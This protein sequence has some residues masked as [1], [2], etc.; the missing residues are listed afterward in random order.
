MRIGILGFFLSFTSVLCAQNWADSLAQ[1]DKDTSA[2]HFLDEKIRALKYADPQ[3]TEELVVMYDSLASLTE[4]TFYLGTAMLHQADRIYSLQKYDEALERYIDI[5]N[6]LE[7][8]SELDLLAKANNNLGSCYQVRNDTKTS[9]AYFVKALDLYRV[10]KDTF[11]IANVNSNLGLQ[12]LNDGYLEEA[13]PHLDEAIKIYDQIDNKIFKGITLLNRGNLRIEQKAYDQAISDYELSRS[14]IP[15]QVSPLINAALKAGMG[16][17]LSHLGS[18]SRA[19]P[20]LLQSLKEAEAINHADQI[21]ES[22]KA[23]AE[24]Y[25][26]IGKF[27]KSLVHYE[28]Y[29]AVKDSLFI[30]AEDSKLADALTR[31]ESEKKENEIVLLN[32]KNEVQETKLAARSRQLLIVGVSAI[33]LLGLLSLVGVL[34]KKNRD[35]KNIIASALN[36]KDT[37]LKEIHHRVK[38]NLQVISAL[39]TLQTKYVKDHQAIQ[40]LQEGQG[41]VQSMALIHQDL[42]QHDNLKGVNTKEYFEKLVQNLVQTYNSENRVIKVDYDIDAILLDVDSMIPLGLVVNELTSN[43]LKHGLK[44]EGTGEIFISLREQ[45]GQLVLRLRDTGPGADIENMQTKSFGYSLIRSFA[46]RLDA[47]LTIKNQEGLS[48]QMTIKNYQKVA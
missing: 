32:S 26:A 10:L 45:N 36:D 40:A 18:Y 41:R 42:Y 6:Y 46:R 44:Q 24:L 27:E 39:L 4:D 23:L 33:V 11:W 13:E 7:N 22:H 19:L 2:L 8:T 34:Y 5:L 20:L 21:K 48:V 31:Y 25:R 1:F 14:L 17:A 15:E 30:V 35:Q 28:Q 3:S 9:T 29:I 47:D 37:L 16:A 38:N 43:A 12:Y